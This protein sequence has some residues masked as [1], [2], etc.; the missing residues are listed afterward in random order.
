MSTEDEPL[1]QRDLLDTQTETHLDENAVAELIESIKEAQYFDPTSM[2]PL[3]SASLAAIARLRAYQPPPFA[4]WNRLPL[5]RRAAVLILLFADRRGHAAFPG[6]KA[7]TL[8]ETPFEIARREAFEEIGLPQDDKKLP[9]PFR[10]EHLCELP[11]NLAR[12]ALAVRPCVAFLHSDDTSGM[13]SASVE[14]SMIPRLDA[15]E[16][17]AVF[18]APFHNFLRAEDEVRENETVPGKRSD[19]YS[20]S[21]SDWNKTKWRMHDFQVPIVN[22]MVSKPKSRDGGQAA[23]AEEL[24]HEELT[25]YRVWGMT[26]RILVD[27][28]RIA[29]GEDPEFE[30]NTHLGDERMIENLEKMGQMKEK[31]PGGPDLSRTSLEEASKKTAAEMRKSDAKM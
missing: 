7:D 20:G 17:A 21:W 1:D 6:G 14:E 8:E 4:T 3:T 10:V 16:V 12:T 9:P 11:Y 26:A 24:D 23:I 27:A 28:A 13:K 22:Q 5:S 30:F 2:A 15:K 29:Y 18:S 19:W 25:R 31:K